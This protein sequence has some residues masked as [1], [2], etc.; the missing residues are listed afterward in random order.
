MSLAREQT[1]AAVATPPG[2]GGIAIIRVSGP[3]VEAIARKLFRPRRP[4]RTFRNHHLY[5]GTIVSPATGGAIDEV[6][7]S[8][9]RKPHSYTGEDVLEI[10]CHGGPFIVGAVLEEVFRAGA[11][12]AEPGE[13][14]RRAFL[15]DR[16]DLAQAEAVGDLIAA[17]TDQGRE[18]ALRH[19]SG[20]LSD[21]VVRLKATL[22]DVLVHLETTIDFAEEEG[23]LPPMDEHTIRLC[24]MIDEIDTVLATWRE[25]KV[26]R[27]GLAAVI[28]GKPNVGKSSLLNR[29]VG[30]R[31]AIVTEIPGTTRDFIE[32]TVF[33]EGIAV[34]FI[35]TAGIR[36]SDE[37][38]ERE[39]MR[40]VWEK[41][42][43]ADLVLVL[44]DGS[45]PL[46][47][48]DIEIIKRI[49][50][51]PVLAV[52]NK[53]DL[54]AAFTDGQVRDILQ[55]TEPLRISAKYGEGMDRLKKRIREAAIGHQHSV[56]IDLILGNLR[57]KLALERTRAL[58]ENAL[59]GI[60]EGLSPELP[61]LDVREAL[62]A[63]GEIVGETTTEEVLDRI[64]STFCIGK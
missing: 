53:S 7:I 14:T 31:R 35:D 58:V 22:V 37:E 3:G 12:P 59:R 48:E 36:D 10:H 50:D 16:L 29:F 42:S 41:V 18:L 20:A 17:R 25:G 4:R 38:I 1:I 24:A 11:R 51:R 60:E 23:H 33:V 9:M 49:G 26:H 6:L 52:I 54:P 19:L 28:A 45:I 55:D 2:T 63:L 47:H 15:N 62:D 46:D 13:F 61:A 27:T 64:F 40:F 34:R 44:F 21:M 39:G 8:I 43:D 5:N 32:E 57:H 30:K 56:S